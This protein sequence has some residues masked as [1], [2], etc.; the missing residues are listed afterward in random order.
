MTNIEFSQ[1]Q[2]TSSW[3]KLV[4]HYE[5]AQHQQHQFYQYIQLLLQENEKYNIT[6]IDSINEVIADHFYDSLALTKLYDMN[7]VQHIVDVGSGGGFPG[8]PLAIK[9]QEVQ[10]CLVEVNLK[11]VHFL[12][13]VIQ[14]LG[15]SNVT[16]QTHDWRTF[17]RTY[18]QPVDLFIARA[19]LSVDELLRIFKPS[20][21]YQDSIF[22]YWASKKW[23]PNLP[24]KEYLDSCL[25]YNVG[26]K[27]RQLCFF[28]K[29]TEK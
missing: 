19:S 12:N 27:Q 21:S 3:K 7:Q 29:L 22:V 24:E 2:D 23:I 17:L 25:L 28:K 15:L 6:A 26:E 1:L 18:Q 11:K 16:V 20:S 5:L 10:F 4:T 9:N 14:A 13:L 8:I